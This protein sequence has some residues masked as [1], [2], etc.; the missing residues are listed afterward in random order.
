MAY[1]KQKQVGFSVEH[2]SKCE[3]DN[4][5]CKFWVEL[6]K[7]DGTYYKKTSF[8][9]LRYAIQRHMKTVRGETFDIID[10]EEF[11]PSN[12]VYKAQCV[13][14]KKCGFAKVDNHPPITEEDMELLYS[15]AVFSL[16]TP[17]GL[18]RKVF[19]ELMLHLGRRGLENL[20]ELTV[21]DFVVKRK[22]GVECVLKVSDEM[23]KN[24]R[25]DQE[26]P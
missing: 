1:L 5:L 18:Q 12:N 24:H 15:S 20:R 2:F 17:I 19:F 25:E 14:L 11:A 3:L 4:I 22:N 21:N 9:C 26:N 6:R 13:V 16:E 8:R 10:N 7:V 23:A